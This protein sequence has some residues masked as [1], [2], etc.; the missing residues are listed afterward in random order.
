MLRART[1]SALHATF[2]G[3]IVFVSPA[4]AQN[5]DL[6]GVISEMALPGGLRG[7]LTA[8]DDRAAPD[9]SQFLLEFIRRSYDA[10]YGAK[11]DDR[12]AVLQALLA[13]LDRSSLLSYAPASRET[14]PLPLSAALWIDVVFGGRATPQTLVGA[15]LRSRGAAL[16]YHGLLSLDDPTRAWLATQPELVADLAS[17]HP[18]AFVAAAAGLR[19][20]G[21]AVR[22]PGG[23]LAEPV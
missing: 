3:V 21:T 9:H 7:A 14:L 10:P 11:S 15:I 19:V 16:L 23:E 1:L 8:V 20:S 5:A 17:R 4:R 6:P 2:I 13:Q 12:E 18:A 22:V